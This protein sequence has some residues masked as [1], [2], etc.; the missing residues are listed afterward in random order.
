MTVRLQLGD[1]SVNVVRKNIKNVHLSVYPPEGS[2]RISVPE[3]MNIKTVRIFAISKLAWIKQ[4]QKKLRAQE[5]ETQREFVNRESHYVW[6]RRYLLKVI[7]KDLAPKVELTPRQLLLQVR[8]NTNTAKRRAIVDDWYR[9]QLRAAAAPLIDRWQ[10]VIGVKASGLFVQ[11]MKT[12][13][14]SCNPLAKTIRL[15]TELAKKP[16]ECL[17]YIVVHELVHLLE[18]THNNRFQSLMS[19]FMPTWQAHRAQ[20]NRL[21]VRH[22]EWDY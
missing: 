12:K 10:K 20:L 7:E 8:F 4:Q 15:N 3:S 16:L 14:G 19:L 21:P 13:W 1:V 5:R 22:Q 6:G 17:E 2:V 18:P 11:S 9:L